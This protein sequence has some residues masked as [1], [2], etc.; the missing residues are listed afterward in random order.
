LTRDL[1]L[2]RTR[3]IRASLARDRHV[4]LALL[5]S[6]LSRQSAGEGELAGL[7]IRSTPHDFGEEDILPNLK[8]A[9]ALPETL[10]ECLALECEK[11]LECLAILLAE[12]LDLTHEG[13]SP[14]DE[15]RQRLG[16]GIAAALDLDMSVHWRADAAFWMRTSKQ[17]ALDALAETAAFAE[18]SDNARAAKM[19]ALAKLRKDEFVAEAARAFEDSRWLPECLITPVRAG[20]FTLAGEAPADAAP[21]RA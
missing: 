14:R 5:V 8:A 12:T 17:Y 3:A 16:D 18:L 6:T 9:R 19:K 4:A 2:A 10:A 13:A 15:E 21:T 20:A 11:L 1:T 7:G